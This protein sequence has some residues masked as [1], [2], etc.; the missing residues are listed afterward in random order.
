MECVLKKS[1]CALIV[2]AIFSFFIVAPAVSQAAPKAVIK[3]V[4]DNASV[5]VLSNSYAPGAVNPMV[6]R[7]NS[8][9]VIVAGPQKFKETFANGHSDIQSHKTGDAYWS[10]SATKSLTNIGSNT[11]QTLVIQIKK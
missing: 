6:K 4:L 3:V 2:A 8:V 10:A 7:A 11:V 5:H 1:L 9:I